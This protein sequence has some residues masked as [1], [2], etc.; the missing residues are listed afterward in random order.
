[1]ECMC[2]LQQAALTG[3]NPAIHA[4]ALAQRTTKTK[5]KARIERTGLF[6][7]KR[8]AALV[9]GRV[10]AGPVIS[11]RAAETAVALEL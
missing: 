2:R 9:S 10:S 1:M 7:F 5:Q 8:R 4:A 6:F 3:E 11:P